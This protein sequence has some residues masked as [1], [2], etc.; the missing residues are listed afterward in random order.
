MMSR[1]AYQNH[2]ENLFYQKAREM[3]WLVTKRGW[4]DFLV[5]SNPGQWFAVEVKPRT[6]KHKRLKYLREEQ[7]QCFDFLESNGVECYVSDGITLE[8]YDNAIHQ[9][10]S[11]RTP[12]RS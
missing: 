1:D 12:R 3:G 5:A 11:S 7:V 8:R 4:P 2:A 6:K 9:R 10:S